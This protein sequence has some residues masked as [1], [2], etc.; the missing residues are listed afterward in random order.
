MVSIAILTTEKDLSERDDQSDR[1]L[2]K[3]AQLVASA[4]NL[5]QERMELLERVQVLSSIGSLLVHELRSPLTTISSRLAIIERM[6][7]SN[8]L[9]ERGILAQAT[10]IHQAIQAAGDIATGLGAMESQHE[11]DGHRVVSALSMIQ[12]AL[13][14]LGRRATENGVNIQMG[15]ISSSIAVRCHPSQIIQVLLNLLNNA[16]EALVVSEEKTI[17]IHCMESTDQIQFRISDTGPGIPADLHEKVFE[18][19]FSTK[20]DRGG[21][22][23]GLGVCR[24]IVAAHFGNLYIDPSRSSGCTLILELP[25]VSPEQA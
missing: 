14:L 25:K 3:I 11:A 8:P 18:H 22:G 7:A 1:K 16:I 5:N 23:L 4:L 15:L 21:N 24:R 6:V 2:Q 20:K 19:R 10:L 12:K 17:R 13:S 9:D